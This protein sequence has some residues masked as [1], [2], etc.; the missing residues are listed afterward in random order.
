MVKL[1][2]RRP[3]KKRREGCAFLQKRYG[4]TRFNGLPT[5]RE[6]RRARQLQFTNRDIFIG[7][8]DANQDRSIALLQ[9][10]LKNIRAARD[11]R[12]RHPRGRSVDV[13]TLLKVL[14]ALAETDTV[15][16]DWA[17]DIS[18]SPA[19]KLLTARFG[20]SHFRAQSILRRLFDLR[21]L[22]PAEWRSPPT[23]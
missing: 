19:H 6:M 14:G 18:Q 9:A 4:G 2:A 15:L 20:F 13:D 17:D 12:R 21:S 5:D 10:V 8:I 23:G 3:Q 11:L 1:A 22:L 16:R 7:I